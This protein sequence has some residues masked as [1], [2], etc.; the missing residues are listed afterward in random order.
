MLKDYFKKNGSHAEIK[1]LLKV[2]HN[3][4]VSLT[5]IKRSLKSLNLTRNII[6]SPLEDVCSAVINELESSGYNL[7][8]RALWQKLKKK[9][10]LTVKR[11]TMYK[12]LRQ[13][14]S[15][16]INERFDNKLRRRQYL[17]QGPNYL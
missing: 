5:S 16:G 6:E 13:V 9:Y 1:D 4:N 8:Y 10:S 7:G 14:Y 3:I 12:I 17:S 11:D 15:E 2:N